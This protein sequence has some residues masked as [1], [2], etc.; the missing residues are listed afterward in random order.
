M[1]RY[2]SNRTTD[3]AAWWYLRLITTAHFVPLQNVL[4]LNIL[5]CFTDWTGQRTVGITSRYLLFD[6]YVPPDIAM[7]SNLVPVI[8]KTP[9]FLNIFGILLLLVVISTLYLKPTQTFYQQVYWSSRFIDFHCLVCIHKFINTKLPVFIFQGYLQPPTDL[10]NATFQEKKV[11]EESLNVCR[12]DKKDLATLYWTPRKKSDGK[13]MRRPK[14]SSCM[15][16]WSSR[17]M[18]LNFRF[19]IWRKKRKCWKPTR[20]STENCSITSWRPICWTLLIPEWRT[21]SGTLWLA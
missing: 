1:I 17:R 13:S 14:T 12:D 15:K 2:R 21:T 16:R 4:Q 20:H 8:K 11:L 9:R 19:E 6:F 10:I 5:Y 3:L 18:K 7:Y